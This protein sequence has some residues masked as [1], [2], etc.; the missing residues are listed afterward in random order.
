MTSRRSGPLEKTMGPLKRNAVSI[1]GNAI[2][3]A[4]F[5]LGLLAH[6]VAA[7]S[8]GGVIQDESGHPLWGALVELK[9]P[10]GRNVRAVGTTETGIFRFDHVPSGN[11]EIV[12]RRD[13]YETLV[14]PISV[15]SSR[16]VSMT[17]SLAEAGGPRDGLPAIV[18]TQPPDMTSLS[19][20]VPVTAKAADCARVEKVELYIDGELQASKESNSIVY[21]WDTT[22]F[23]NGGHTILA[24]AYDADGRV[25]RSQWLT[26]IVDNFQNDNSQDR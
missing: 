14:T 2:L 15:S 26:V 10:P 13:G 25:G 9:H 23:F 24:K 4:S 5:I 21:P 1:G 19:G 12:V 18:V 11:Y 8:L 7:T 22:A 20:I 17:F 16:R 3:L 6:A